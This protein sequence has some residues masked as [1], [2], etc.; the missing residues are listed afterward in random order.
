M[1][2]AARAYRAQTHSY[3]LGKIMAACADNEFASWL[4]TYHSLLW[5]RSGFNTAIKCDHINNNLAES[6]NNKVKDLKDLPVHD[7]VDQIRIMIMRLWDLRGRLG[8]MLEGDKLPAVVQ[9]V[10]NKSRNLSHLSVEKSSLFDAEVKDARSV[11]RHVVN[12]ELQE[13]T[14]L[15][16]QH[17][18]KPCEHAII[19]LASKPRLNMHPYLHE[20]YSVQKFK[21]AYAT[22]IPALTDQ[23]QWPEVDI[24]FT[25]CPPLSKRKAGRPK[26]SR[27]KAWFEKGGCSKKGKKEKPEKP[28]RAQ[29]GNKNRCKLCEELGHRIGSPKCRYTPVQPKYVNV[30]SP[31]YVPCFICLFQYLIYILVPIYMLF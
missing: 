5:Y 27:Y 10:V 2:P 21:A 9:Q 7:M 31:I 26:Q 25:L 19:F 17:T 28:K 12:I 3:H 15:E 30:N 11:K 13:C 20:Y 8:D 29:K 22:P 24:E 6:F 14:C 18:G 4:N 23:S 16:W 1:W